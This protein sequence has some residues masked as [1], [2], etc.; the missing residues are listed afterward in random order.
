MITD[1]HVI[2][3]IERIGEHYCTNISNRFVRPVL[4]QLPL[5]K[6]LWDAIEILTKEMEQY[7]YQGFDLQE[8]Y[9][10]VSACARFVYLTRRDILPTLRSRVTAPP[11]GVDKVFSD[12]AVHNFGSN[13]KVFADLVNELYLRLVELDKRQAGGHR[14][15]Y[16]TIPELADVGRFLVGSE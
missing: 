16:L 5:E 11:S 12:M 1:P 15:L 8:L 14:P 13:L 6:H 10:Q 7:Q 2:R 9:R 4:L 3:L